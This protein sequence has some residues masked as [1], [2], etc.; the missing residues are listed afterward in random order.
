[1]IINKV[2]TVDW[3]DEE[4]EIMGDFRQ[5]LHNKMEEVQ[6][7]M[8]KFCKELDDIDTKIWHLIKDNHDE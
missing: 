1:M 5:F 7:L 2:I 8:P 6:H 3:T 4:M